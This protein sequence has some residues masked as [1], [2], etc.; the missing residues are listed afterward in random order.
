LNIEVLDEVLK[1][2]K[3]L[4]SMEPLDHD[5]Y[6]ALSDHLKDEVDLCTQHFEDFIVPIFN[7]KHRLDMNRNG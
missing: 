1:I 5:G 3:G 7:Q 6:R 2:V 4:A